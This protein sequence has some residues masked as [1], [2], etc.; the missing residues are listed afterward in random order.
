MTR[1]VKRYWV[2]I[3][4]WMVAHALV[5]SLVVGGAVPLAPLVMF[6]VGLN[7]AVVRIIFLEMPLPRCITAQNDH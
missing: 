5:I 4:C 2:T 6:L 1:K 3:D 7:F